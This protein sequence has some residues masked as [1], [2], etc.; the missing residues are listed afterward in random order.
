MKRVAALDLARGFAGLAMIQAHAYDAYV[1]APYRGGFAFAATRFVALLEELGGLEA[2]VARFSLLA[3]ERP[4]ASSASLAAAD[5]EI[6]HALVGLSGS[7]ERVRSPADCDAAAQRLAEP[8][9]SGR[10]SRRGHR[11]L[12]KSHPPKIRP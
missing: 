8:D 4:R 6:L 12:R 10:A 9:P 5:I 11:V 7:S 1:D 3:E 2:R